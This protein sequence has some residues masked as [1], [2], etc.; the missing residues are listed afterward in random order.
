MCER[1][2]QTRSSF[3][4]INA[5]KTYLR[6]SWPYKTPITS[7]RSTLISVPTCVSDTHRLIM[8]CCVLKKRFSFTIIFCYFTPYLTIFFFFLNSTLRHKPSRSSYRNMWHIVIGT[9]IL[10]KHHLS[11][12]SAC[13]FLFSFPALVFWVVFCF[14][15]FF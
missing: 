7:L 1:A 15:C 13:F 10:Y 11:G 4:T 5:S 14:F 2:R 9:N 3:F 8:L 6:S 12:F